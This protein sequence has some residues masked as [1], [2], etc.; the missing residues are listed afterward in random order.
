VVDS[1][2]D[3]VSSIKEDDISSVEEDVSSPLEIDE[4]I[5]SGK[6]KIQS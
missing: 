4:D 1:A 2:L 5:V 6:E 3:D